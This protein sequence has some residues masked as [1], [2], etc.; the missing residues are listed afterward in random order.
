[1]E[2]R[3]RTRGAIRRTMSRLAETGK[4]MCVSSQIYFQ[5]L[6]LSLPFVLCVFLKPGKTC[7][8][9]HILSTSALLEHPLLAYCFWI[10]LMGIL[11]RDRHKANVHLVDIISA[12]GR[13]SFVKLQLPKMIFSSTQVVGSC[14]GLI[15]FFKS[16]SWGNSY[17]CNPNRRRKC[18]NFKTNS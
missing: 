18:C 4:A 5:D 3:Y 7:S 14:N 10:P 6:L 1:M 2:R 17:I 15:C 16:F 13:C 8:H 12:L 9:L 11:K